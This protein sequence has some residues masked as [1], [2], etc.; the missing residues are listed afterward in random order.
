MSANGDGGKKKGSSS[1]KGDKAAIAAERKIYR[2][3]ARQ[4]EQMWIM[5]TGDEGVGKTTLL[6]V[7]MD[8]DF[9][10]SDDYAF[11]TTD[12]A[13]VSRKGWLP[14]IYRKK[15]P[16]RAKGIVTLNIRDTGGSSELEELRLEFYSFQSVLFICLPLYFTSKKK[17][18]EAIGR[19]KN[20]WV[21][22]ARAMNPKLP[23]VLVGTKSDERDN[24]DLQGF[25]I[26]QK[27][28]KQLAAHVGAQDYREVS[29][30][31]RDAVEALFKV[32][33][34]LHADA[35]HGDLELAKAKNEKSCFVM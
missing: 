15:L 23:F 20:F 28:G 7:F 31:T 6:N 9:I 33:F 35:I 4:L 27:D 30:Y 14:E 19:I 34:D 17:A 29:C 24:K 1:K 2:K 8:K 32:G 26:S 13:E 21:K 10:P 22:E 18:E 12:L 3:I 11:T 16:K 25:K 5:L